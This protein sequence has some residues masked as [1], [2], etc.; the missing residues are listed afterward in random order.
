MGH[1]AFRRNRTTRAM[2]AK[3]VGSRAGSVDAWGS[4]P[5]WKAGDGCPYFVVGSAKDETELARPLDPF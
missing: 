5:R 4:R 2:R 3:S 1:P